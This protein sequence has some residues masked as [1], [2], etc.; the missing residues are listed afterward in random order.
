MEKKVDKYLN[1]D[2]IFKFILDIIHEDEEIMFKVY[3]VKTH[4]VNDKDKDRS[5]AENQNKW[6][7]CKF[8]WLDQSLKKYQMHFL[9]PVVDILTENG[10]KTWNE[11]NNDENCT[12]LLEEAMKVFQEKLCNHGISWDKRSWRSRA[13]LYW[14][15][16][17]YR[18]A[19]ISNGKLGNFKGFDY[20]GP[21]GILIQK[22][23]E[24]DV[25]LLKVVEKVDL[26]KVELCIHS[27]LHF[28]Y[29][30]EKHHGKKKLGHLEV[31][32]VLSWASATNDYHLV[33]TLLKHNLGYMVW[34]IECDDKWRKSWEE[35]WAMAL[36]NAAYRGHEKVVK[37]LLQCDFPYHVLYSKSFSETNLLEPPLHVAVRKGYISVVD[38]FCSEAS[39]SFNCHEKNGNNHTPLEIATIMKK[40]KKLED[41]NNKKY[42]QIQS[43]LLQ[44]SEVKVT[45][46]ELRNQRQLRVDSANA[47]LVGA[48]LFAS[49]TFGGWLSPPLGY[50]SYY[51]FVEPLPAAPP[52][53]Y[54]SYMSIQGH[55]TIQVFAIFNSLSFFFAIASII[56]GIETIYSVQTIE[57][58]Y[59]TNTMEKLKHK[60]KWAIRMFI[61]SV[62]CSLVAFASAGIAILPPIHQYQR[63]MYITIGIGGIVCLVFLC[64]MF[65]FCIPRRFK[66]SSKINLM[67]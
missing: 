12:T 49:I 37:E 20:I 27:S 42:I 62:I 30:K 51:Q 1:E 53:S 3:D 56:A 50:N 48:T 8:F 54:E 15:L 9:N 60:L 52:N 5:N 55:K 10:T 40:S 61:T 16:G 58:I 65:W 28:D 22:M 25:E 7:P 34:D 19:P 41:P 35:A 44:R 24:A 31:C 17:L 18:H 23:L 47:I 26:N 13:R 43:I 38:V 57:D 36:W 14:L 46:E 2:S 21:I 4:K 11:T 64:K 29:K 6:C 67:N 63:N 66:Y 33:A 39:R 59:I 45:V 32:Q